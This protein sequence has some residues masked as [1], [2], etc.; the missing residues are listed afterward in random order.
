MEFQLEQIEI[1]GQIMLPIGAS[2]MSVDYVFWQNRAWLSP[3]YIASPDGQVRPLRLI[4][5]RMAPGYTAPHGADFLELFQKMPLTNA[6]LEQGFIPDDMTQFL[7]IV[8]N[9]N[10]LITNPPA[11]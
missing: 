4:A 6:V 7:H 1:A 8:E 9:P 3:I 11:G 5:P 2:I 10:V